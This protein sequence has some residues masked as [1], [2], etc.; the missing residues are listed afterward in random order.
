MTREPLW[1]P[2]LAMFAIGGF[3]GALPPKLTGGAPW[4][5]LV[6]IVAPLVVSIIIFHRRD[7]HSVSH[8]LG[9]VLN[10]IVTAALIYSL[11]MLI[12][13]VTEHTVAPQRLMYSAAE[14]W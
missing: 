1:P 7:N 4:W 6:A 14:L 5:L 10:S 2:A 12:L 13:E 3:D 9:Y 11:A 8:F